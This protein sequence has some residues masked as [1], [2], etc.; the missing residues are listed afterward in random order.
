WNS[1]DLLLP[2]TLEDA[3]VLEHHIPHASPVCWPFG[4]KSFPKV[5]FDPTRPLRRAYHLGAMDWLPNQ[6]GIQWFLEKVWPR[7]HAR[8]PAFHFSFG[9]RN[10]P[11]AFTSYQGNQVNCLGQVPSAQDFI[12]DKDILV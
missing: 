4:W 8:F 9:G 11:S 7:V 1:Y 5:D 6:E 12:E 3:Q 10:M 2:I